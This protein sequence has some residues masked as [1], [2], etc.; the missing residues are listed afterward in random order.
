MKIAAI[1]GSIR[2]DS[3]NLK[4]AQ[5]VKERYKDRF[6]LEILSL[7]DLPIYDQDI[8]NTPPEAVTKFKAKVAAADAVLW[9]TPEYNGT[10]SGVL[11]NAID[12]LSRV[13]KVM[14]GKPSWIM[15]ASMG[16]MGTVKAQLHLREIL[17]AM[18]LS[19][20]LLPGNE[21]YVGAVHEKF[22]AE[23]NLI[24]EPTVKFLDAVV[25]NFLKWYDTYHRAT[26]AAK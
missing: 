23:G 6:E 15:G 14:V 19:S 11:G 2:K 12:W 20:P 17:F 22:D 10:I 8:E 1:V 4:L 9:I 13:D 25:D 5:Y 24:H 21:V 3:Y 26:V 18:G 16:L 7:R